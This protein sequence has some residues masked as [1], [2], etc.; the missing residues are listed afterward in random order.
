MGSTVAGGMRILVM[1]LTLTIAACGGGDGDSDR[2][3]NTCTTSENCQG[4][5]ECVLAV[6]GNLRCF[7]RDDSTCTLGSV[8]VGRAPVPTAIP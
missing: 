8:E 1:A 3:C 4:N 5:D 2:E 6:D 7:D